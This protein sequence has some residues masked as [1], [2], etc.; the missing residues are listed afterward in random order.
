MPSSFL[1]ILPDETKL[2]EP[3]FV[4]DKLLL[5]TENGPVTAQLPYYYAPLK[6]FATPRKTWLLYLIPFSTGFSL[7]LIDFTRMAP[8]RVAQILAALDAHFG[9]PPAGGLSGS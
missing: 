5:L 6:S 1:N 3:F 4:G 9:Q 7:D 8:I 2:G